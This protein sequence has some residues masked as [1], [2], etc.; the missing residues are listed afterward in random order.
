MVRARPV[1]TMGW[2]EWVSLPELEIGAI[3]AKADTGA[4]TSSLHA[5][6]VEWF[7]VDGAPWVRF[8]VHPVQRT[9]WAARMV[10]LPVI[11]RRKVKSSTGHV[12]ERPV[13]RT[14]VCLNDRTWPI[15]I[16]LT[17]RDE[18]GFRMLLGRAALRRKFLVDPGRSFLMS[19]PRGGSS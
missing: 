5:F 17:D 7:E 10:E 9:R 4:R 3:K 6:G 14:K 19:D 16:T 1:D 8:E 2:R 12:Q 11:A 13:I 18:M 15:E